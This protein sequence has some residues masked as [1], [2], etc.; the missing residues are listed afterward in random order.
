[1][2][3]DLFGLLGAKAL[4][5]PSVCLAHLALCFGHLGAFWSFEPTLGHFEPFWVIL[6]HYLVILGP[7]V[8]LVARAH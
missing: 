7:S 5:G 4:F 6:R 8:C 2:C 3:S 1:M